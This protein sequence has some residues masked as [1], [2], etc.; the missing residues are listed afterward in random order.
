MV[1]QAGTTIHS[2]R[3][4]I[5]QRIRYDA[6]A[7]GALGDLFSSDECACLGGAINTRRHMLALALIDPR[8]Y[9]A[10]PEQKRAGAARYST[11]RRCNTAIYEYC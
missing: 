3:L 11:L 9:S 10:Q 7:I 2:F 6:P 1:E 5:T 8:H 4:Q